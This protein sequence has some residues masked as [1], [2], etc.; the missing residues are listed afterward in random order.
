M[1]HRVVRHRPASPDERWFG[2]QTMAGHVRPAAV[3]L[4]GAVQDQSGLMLDIGSGTGNG[5]EAA[6]ASGIRSVG[7]DLSAMQLR[8]SRTSSP[9]AQADAQHLPFAGERFGAAVSNFGLV[10]AADPAQVLREAARCLHEGGVAA[11]TAWLPGGWPDECR[12]VMA[13]ALDQTARPF[14]TKLGLE[15]NAR[16]LFDQAG[17]TDIQVSFGELVWSFADLGDAVNTLTQAA[18]GLRTIRSELE[19]HGLWVDTSLQL[20]QVI[21]RRL[22]NGAGQG[23]ELVDPYLLVQGQLA[24]VQLAE[25]RQ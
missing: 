4:V 14:P 5:L 23:Y 21:G 8:T 25:R 11:L 10:F 6:A 16:A 18:G 24:Q 9:L 19:D 13:S 1:D 2:Y 17:F 7:I 12:S 15:A 22:R 3:A 20:E